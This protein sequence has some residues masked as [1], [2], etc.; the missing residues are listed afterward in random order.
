MI[1]WPVGAS[2]AAEAACPVPAPTAA[3]AAD[4]AAAGADAAGAAAPWPDAGAAAPSPAADP[5]LDAP[6]EQPA[7][8]AMAMTISPGTKAAPSRRRRAPICLFRMPFGRRRGR[9]RLR[10]QVT[11]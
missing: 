8:A 6:L 10:A 2:R 4:G 1:C 5:L 11:I 3:P 7:S 9:R